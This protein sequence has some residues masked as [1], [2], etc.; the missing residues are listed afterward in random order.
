MPT[1]FAPFFVSPGGEQDGGTMWQVAPPGP[2]GKER[3]KERDRERERESFSA[4]V[5][6][7][8]RTESRAG[9]K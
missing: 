5:K 8:D 6:M 7:T 9:N 2:K 1:R 3:K 4:A